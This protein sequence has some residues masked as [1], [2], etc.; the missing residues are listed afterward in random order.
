MQK[1]LYTYFSLILLFF[2]CQQV[3]EQEETG[4]KKKINSN[5]QIILVTTY[6]PKREVF[7]YLIQTTGKII[8]FKEQK[9]ISE[10]NGIIKNL[11]LRNNLKVS[12]GAKLLSFDTKL[13]LLKIERTKES[14]FSSRLNYESDLLSQEGL[15]KNKSKGVKDTVLRKLRSNVGLTNAELELKELQLVLENSII[16]APFTGKIANIN[17]QDGQF[18]RAGD[19]LFTIYTDD[20]LYMEC[21]IL[22]SDISNIRTGQQ[23]EIFPVASQQK[24]N[25]K[26]YEI[27]PLVDNNGLVNVKVKVN[28]FQTLLPGMNAT[29]TILVP[30]QKSL[31]VPKSA[32]VI[33][34]GK[35]VVFTMEDG[36]AKWN[37]VVLGRDNGKELE[38]K[39]GLKL[40]QKVIVSNNLQLGHDSPVKEK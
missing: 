31:I 36:L 3:G 4:H 22:E 6:I 30:E 24:C 1:L 18:I 35:P 15:L 21:K 27:N 40:G 8:A 13:I 7:N 14:I 17:V 10:N 12:K 11:S 39:D 23:V 5:H 37:Y 25:G 29:A 16:R 20:L 34:N 9:I 26:I 38:I 19:E 33:R 32:V 2:S 28:E